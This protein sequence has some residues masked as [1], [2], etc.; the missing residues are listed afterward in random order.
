[1]KAQTFVN[2]IRIDKRLQL[3]VG[4]QRKEAKGFEEKKSII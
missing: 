4:Y 2:G 3:S 1:M